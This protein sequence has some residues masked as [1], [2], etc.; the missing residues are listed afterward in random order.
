MIRILIAD[1]H[2]LVRQRLIQ[3][4]TEGFPSSYLVE[5]DDTA[6]LLSQALE[7]EWDIIISDLAMPG[8]GGLFAIEK[9]KNSKAHI[10]VL[11]ISIYPEE[12]Y[13]QRVIQAGAAAFLSKDKADDDL[14]T[15]VR[16]ILS[17]A[18]K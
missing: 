16:S 7:N 13:A 6:S 1:D 12:Q 9:I 15:T 11:I 4:L 3:L 2:L 5:T 17:K 10:P 18:G 14:I 8:G